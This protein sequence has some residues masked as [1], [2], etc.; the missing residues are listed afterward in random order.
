M[1]D[2]DLLSL[3]NKFIKVHNQ[4]SALKRLSVIKLEDITIYPIE[5]Q[6]LSLISLRNDLTITEIAQKLYMTKSGASQI[7]KKLYRKELITK[8]RNIDNERLVILKMTEIGTDVLNNYF[9]NNEE[10][11]LFFKNISSLSNPEIETI[12]H[13]L[14]IM[15]DTYDHKLK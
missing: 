13:F 8:S 2:V 7:V 6:V 3:Y 10:L 11:D 15:D 9:K 12:N 5:M 1:Y 4:L 14:N